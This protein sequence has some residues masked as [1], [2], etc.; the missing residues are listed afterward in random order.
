MCDLNIIDIE[1][2]DGIQRFNSFG[3]EKDFDF[4]ESNNE[5][6]FNQESGNCYYYHSNNL[7]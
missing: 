5:S 4:I 6:L 3:I 1:R 7:S 2:I